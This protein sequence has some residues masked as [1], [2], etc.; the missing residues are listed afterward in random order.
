MSSASQEMELQIPAEFAAG[1]AIQTAQTSAQRIIPN[2][3][4][5]SITSSPQVIKIPTMNMVKTN[6]MKL[7]KAQEDE[8]NT[9]LINIE[10]VRIALDSD[11]DLINGAVSLPIGVSQEFYVVADDEQE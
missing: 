4:S 10:E 6:F 9:D 5:Q 1:A 8:T 11:I 3:K 2:I 7:V